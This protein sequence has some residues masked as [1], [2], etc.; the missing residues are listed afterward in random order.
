VADPIRYRRIDATEFDPR[1][2]VR[3][4]MYRGWEGYEERGV[5][6]CT[7]C[8]EYGEYGGC[9][10]GANPCIGL[11]CDECGYTGK[12]RW[13]HWIAFDMDA[14]IVWEFKR[15][16]RRERLL[17]FWRRQRSAA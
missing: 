9:S 5:G 3:V 12:R 14:F 15:Y 6:P 4:V 16:E 11:G 7:G 1:R 10:C 2:R 13:R 8:H 17:A